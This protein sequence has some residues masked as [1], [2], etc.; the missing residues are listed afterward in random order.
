M[1]TGIIVALFVRAPLTIWLC[2][3]IK[4]E[5]G[6]FTGLGFFLVFLSIECI[7]AYMRKANKLAGIV[8][9]KLKT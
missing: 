2:W 7:A 8:I 1:K 4:E 5:T 6:P 9:S 3:K